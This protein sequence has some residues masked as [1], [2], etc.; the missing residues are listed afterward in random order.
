M[1]PTEPVTQMPSLAVHNEGGIRTL[2]LNRAS[3]RNAL[4]TALT[5]SL[6]DELR[7]AEADPAVR[8]VVITGAGS[9]FCA[10]AYLR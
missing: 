4:D 5:Q 9:V 10:G 8:A 6:L 3:C 1:H 2:T 7:R